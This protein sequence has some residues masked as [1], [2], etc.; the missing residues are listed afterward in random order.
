M[1]PSRSVGAHYLLNQ[2]PQYSGWLKKQGGVFGRSLMKKY[3]ILHNNV[4]Y[5]FNDNTSSVAILAFNTK[6]VSVLRSTQ[7]KSRWSFTISNNENNKKPFC[8]VVGSERE[9]QEWLKNFEKD[10]EYVTITE[11]TRDM[12]LDTSQDTSLPRA[13]RSAPDG[14]SD[15]NEKLEAELNI[16]G[17]SLKRGLVKGRD[18]IH[19]GKPTPYIHEESTTEARYQSNPERRLPSLP[20][21]GTTPILP[22]LNPAVAYDIPTVKP[23]SRKNSLM[24]Y[25][26]IEDEYI[27]MRGN[28]LAEEGHYMVPE[29]M[30]NIYENELLPPSVYQW[31]F[32]REDANSLLTSISTAGLYLIRKGSDGKKV[33][34]A[35]LESRCR[36]Y[37]IFHDEDKVY[38]KRDEPHFQSLQELIGHYR[39]NNLPTCGA[40]LEQPYT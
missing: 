5:I 11:L 35:Y 7:N 2:A 17:G 16:S 21:T 18:F 39:T 13:T 9:L 15:I 33:L 40:N 32:N 3:G 25:E 8:F 22:G 27:P 36:H 30:E 24:Q 34:S 26:V 10:E 20:N 31:E 38:L 23:L 19:D 37:I 4:F 6:T 28:T 14:A 29:E 12:E 1:E